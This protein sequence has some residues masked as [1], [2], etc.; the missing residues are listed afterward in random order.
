MVCQSS[1]CPKSVISRKKKINAKPISLSTRAA[2]VTFNNNMEK[3]KEKKKIVDY[4]CPK[5]QQSAKNTD[6]L[7]VLD[8]FGIAESE[9]M[10]GVGLS[11]GKGKIEFLRNNICNGCIFCD[12]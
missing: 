10:F 1:I 2:P 9:I 3:T 11:E 7:K 12:L 5:F 4:I 6:I 8:L